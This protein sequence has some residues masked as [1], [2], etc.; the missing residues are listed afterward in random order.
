MM[1]PE[2]RFYV[3]FTT[4]CLGMLSF[5]IV[6]ITLGAILPDLVIGLDMNSKQAGHL[7]ALLPFGILIGSLLFGPIVDRYSYKLVFV[8]AAG[9]IAVTLFLIANSSQLAELKLLFLMTG[10]GGG[11]LN[12]STNGL[13]SDISDQN[14]DRRGSNL[15]FLG[16]FFGL[17]ALIMPVL[18]VQ[19]AIRGIS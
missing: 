9:L 19:F 17:G 8:I 18:L 14:P 7:S 12:G 6:V 4:S 15:N 13:V 11:L 5:G 1:S 2:V 3:L 10:T 16:V